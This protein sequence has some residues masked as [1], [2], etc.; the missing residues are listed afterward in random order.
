MVIPPVP[1]GTIQAI[2]PVLS[3]L[4]SM[5]SMASS[6]KN[7]V[8][9]R[10]VSPDEAIALYKKSAKPAE[11]RLLNDPKFAASVKATLTISGPLLDQFAKEAQKCEER[12][13]QARNKANTENEKTQAEISAA[14]C[15]CSVLRLIKLRN[16]DVLPNDELENWWNSYKCTP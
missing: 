14:E 16:R 1:P 12:H 7:L 5:L 2:A 13:I 4:A 11:L 15:I 6:I 8:T 3:M 9:Q 10:K